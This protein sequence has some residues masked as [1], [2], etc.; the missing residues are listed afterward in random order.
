M[1]SESEE[2]AKDVTGLAARSTDSEGLVVPAR[3]KI[4]ISGNLPPNNVIAHVKSTGARRRESSRGAISADEQGRRREDCVDVRRRGRDNFAE[5]G[6]DTG[7]YSEG[8]VTGAVNRQ[9]TMN[10]VEMEEWR[11]VRRKKKC[12]AARPNDKLVGGARVIYKRNMKCGEVEK[13]RCRLVA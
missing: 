8:H 13:Y 7:A 12:K 6:G 3:R 1:P 2:E 9:Q 10:T 4:T 11:K 5:E